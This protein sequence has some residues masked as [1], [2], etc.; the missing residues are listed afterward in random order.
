MGE[1]GRSMAGED[2]P[3]TP[4]AAADLGAI[5]ARLPTALDPEAAAGV[6]GVRRAHSK[7]PTARAFRGVRG[8]IRAFSRVEESDEEERVLG[9]LAT[10]L[11]L[12][13]DVE[14]TLHLLERLTALLRVR[15]SART[16]RSKR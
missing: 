4:D 10:D 1:K 9:E 15:V 5:L 2:T 8:F 3:R 13:K 11:A 14:T 7:A 12:Q 16:A 6:E